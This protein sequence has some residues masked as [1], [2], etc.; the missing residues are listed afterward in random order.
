[1]FEHIDFKNW[2]DDEAY[3]KLLPPVEDVF[4]ANWVKHF[5]ELLRSRIIDDQRIRNFMR[6]EESFKEFVETQNKIFDKK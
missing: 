4:G 6:L 3:E 1:M 5:D 2:G